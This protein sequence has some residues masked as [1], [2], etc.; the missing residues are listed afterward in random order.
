MECKEYVYNIAVSLDR[1]ANAIL[2]GRYSE[3]LSSRIYRNSVKGYWYAKAG[4]VIL[5]F[6]FKPWGES[7]C[8]E[9]YENCFA[10][11]ECPKA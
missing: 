9:S 11:G 5:D 2:F 4:V 3:T 8:K 6:I 7:H 10:K 1:L